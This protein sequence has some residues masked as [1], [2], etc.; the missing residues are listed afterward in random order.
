MEL[1]LKLG[2]GKYVLTISEA[3]MSA[4][5]GTFT[6]YHDVDFALK[7]DLNPPKLLNR[8]VSMKS[9]YKA[10]YGIADNK[11]EFYERLELWSS[12]CIRSVYSS[13]FG[14]DKVA[15]LSDRRKH[16]LLILD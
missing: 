5:R 3:Q 13:N 2:G 11:D 16:L 15:K 8:L 4:V 12:N 1:G 10:A 7:D 9:G 6:D 14:S